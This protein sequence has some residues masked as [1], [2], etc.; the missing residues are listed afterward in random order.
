M[1]VGTVR[2]FFD[3]LLEQLDGNATMCNIT[4]QVGHLEFFDVRHIL[5][6]SFLIFTLLATFYRP[7][8]VLA[9]TQ[10]LAL[11]ICIVSMQS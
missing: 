3:R 11:K 6:Q 4:C 7:N 9:I 10:Q 1:C 5:G 2:P 8:D